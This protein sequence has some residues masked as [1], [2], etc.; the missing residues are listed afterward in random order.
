MYFFHT[1][2]W[3]VM[4]VRFGIF[5]I[6]IPLSDALPLYDTRHN[7]TGEEYDPEDAMYVAHGDVRA[8]LR[9]SLE[10]RGFE[11][12]PLSIKDGQ[13]LT[14][15]MRVMRA[16]AGIERRMEELHGFKKPEQRNFMSTVNYV[17]EMD[18]ILT[19]QQAE[20]IYEHGKIRQKRKM[21]ASVTSLWNMPIYYYYG[22]T[23]TPQMEQLVES[24]IKEWEDLTCLNFSRSSGPVTWEQGNRNNVTI[25]FT[26]NGC[27]SYVGKKENANNIQKVSV[28]GC[29]YKGRIAH[30]LGHV[31][32][33]WHEQ[34][35]PDRNDH[36][37]IEAP[38]IMDN[39]HGDFVQLSWQDIMA[40]GVPYDVG[41]VMHYGSTAFSK[42]GNPTVV[43]RIPNL[44]R[45]LGQRHG[46]SFYDVK[47]ANSVYCSGIC[48]G[49][50]LAQPCKHGGY[51]D[52]T[53]CTACRCP[54]GLS[55][56]FCETTAPPVGLS[57]GGDINV[58]STPTSIGH[59]QSFQ[60]G[61][62]C[63][64]FIRAPHG[65][66]V[67]LDL[68][69][70]FINFDTCYK[71]HFVTC[72]SFLEVRYSADLAN[73]GARYCCSLKEGVGALISESNEMVV[74]LRGHNNGSIGF[75]ANVWAESCGGCSLI[76]TTLSMTTRVR[77]CFQTVFKTCRKTWKK[78][79]WVP[80]KKVWFSSRVSNNCNKYR[81]V[82][83]SRDETCT[84]VVPTCCSNFHLDGNFCVASSGAKDDDAVSPDIPSAPGPSNDDNATQQGSSDVI[85]W[86]TWSACSKACGGCGNKTRHRA[87]SNPDSCG[88]DDNEEIEGCS[89]A[90]CE[91]PIM[92]TCTRTVATKE[93]CPPWSDNTCTKYRTE[94]YTCPDPDMMCC[95]GYVLQGGLCVAVNT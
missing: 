76:N 48:H 52:P 86:S 40:M 28:D 24:V 56:D 30:E 90:P 45:A 23:H 27:W 15:K 59:L 69:G 50:Q 75:K 88:G 7:L 55:G 6:L 68:V 53:Q 29:V 3:T 22:G 89:F 71:D 54:E 35:R 51:Q 58:T 14:D 73:T 44:Q 60:K 74:L 13:S 19:P 36:V 80:C 65:M 66:N 46:L 78:K 67:H 11:T 70:D 31:I 37:I 47:L 2:L 64:W 38:N 34:A 92:T 57:C 82:D 95:K 41:S 72:D 10:N 81:M 26:P 42:A 4:S 9:S 1:Y 21:S 63:N 84:V 18:I 79:E 12:Q 16:L 5:V 77:P 17:Y 8:R 39:K 49:V 33:F 85:G 94:T 43:S 87:C 32:G 62:K 83:M 91:T 93:F 25:E 20:T 61:H